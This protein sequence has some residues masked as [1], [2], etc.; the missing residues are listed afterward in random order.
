MEPEEAEKPYYQYPLS[1]EAV[2]ALQSDAHLIA[3][4]YT[5]C[6]ATRSDYAQV[7][8]MKLLT[9][10]VRSQVPPKRVIQRAIERYRQKERE[11]RKLCTPFTDL[12]I[13]G[14]VRSLHNPSGDPL[15]YAELREFVGLGLNYNDSKVAKLFWHQ[16]RTLLQIAEELD[17]NEK[18]VLAVLKRVR[19]AVKERW[20]N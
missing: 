19:L 8:L 14:Q 5:K 20:L 3:A 6:E 11:K 17:T 7:G 1:G 2:V 4:R 10:K 13:G 18:A 16:N 12:G 9:K 15:T